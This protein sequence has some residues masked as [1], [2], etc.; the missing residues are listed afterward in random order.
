MQLVPRTAQIDSLLLD[1]NNYRF[2]DL[3][4][5]NRVTDNRFHETRIQANAERLLR[6]NRSFD[7][8]QLKDSIS[9][10]GFVP[11]EQIVVTSY[12]ADA[13]KYVVV[14]GNRRVAA[15]KWLLEDNAAG[16]L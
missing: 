7:L 2:H 3:E 8:V 13:T 1:A 10:N 9:T 4:G 16:V 6:D 5:W 14:E 15:I 12:P 11:L